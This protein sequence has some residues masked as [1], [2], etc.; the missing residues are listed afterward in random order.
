MKSSKSDNEIDLTVV[1]PVFNEEENIEKLTDELIS[2]LD[3]LPLSYEVLA[4]HV[5]S[6]DKSYEVL[7]KLGKRYEHFYP[8]NMRYL[9]TKGYQKGYQYMLGF[10]A[11]KGKRVVQ[12][13]S[14]YQDD[15]KDIPRFLEKL[16]EGYDLVVGWKQDRKDPPFY[17]LTSSLLNAVPRIGS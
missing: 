11:A 5:P 16:D 17:T 2:V 4:V 14:D 7:K 8:V 15:P 1:L 3:E 13:D 10:R 6:R 12:M 9:S